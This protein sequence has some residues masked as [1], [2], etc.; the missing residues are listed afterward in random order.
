MSQLR[1]YRVSQQGVPT[2]CPNCTDPAWC[3]NQKK[4]G[5]QA[6]DAKTRG[7]P[8]CYATTRHGV[9]GVGTRGGGGGYGCGR[10]VPVPVPVRYWPYYG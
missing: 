10:W 9:A 2:G 3:P 8:G 6:P 4:P 1:V 5:E 7:V